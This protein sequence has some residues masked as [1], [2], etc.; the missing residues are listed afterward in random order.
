MEKDISKD[1]GKLFV[2]IFK[3]KLFL[4]FLKCVIFCGM[5]LFL[6]WRNVKG[7]IFKGKKRIRLNGSWFVLSDRSV[8]KF[9]YDSDSE[10]NFEGFE[11]GD[12]IGYSLF[13]S[14]VLFIEINE[15]E[16]EE[17]F[18]YEWEIE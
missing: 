2:R 4:R 3:L 5:L 11:K 18:D 12:L 1:N 17:N 6:I 16:F 10:L 7:S 9:L 8:N 13:C 15:V 14:D